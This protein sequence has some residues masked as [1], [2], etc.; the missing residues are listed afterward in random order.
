MKSEVKHSLEIPKV[1]K[2]APKRRIRNFFIRLKDS[3]R[4]KRNKVIKP[5]KNDS[6][7]QLVFY[8]L[9]YG[10]VINYM[11]WIVFRIPFKWY[12]FPAYG[13][14]LYLI[15]SEVLQIW[16]DLWFKTEQ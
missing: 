1:Q 16:R 15:K 10:L 7:N 9:I 11:F 8:A 14:F 4:N 12:G 13:I 3:F 2:S 6:V 5:L